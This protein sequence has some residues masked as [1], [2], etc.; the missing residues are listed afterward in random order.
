MSVRRDE[1]CLYYFSNSKKHGSVNV[2]SKTPLC[3]VRMRT[4]SG[5]GYLP[6]SAA[7]WHRERGYRRTRSSVSGFS[8]AAAFL[9]IHQ[10]RDENAVFLKT[11]VRV[12]T[13]DTS[14]WGSI[15]EPMV[16]AAKRT[17]EP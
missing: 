13:G 1:K 10:T 12:R 17:S 5:V 16:S 8:L 11:D 7:H 3:K 2:A 9:Q 15:S 14:A 6:A 4:G